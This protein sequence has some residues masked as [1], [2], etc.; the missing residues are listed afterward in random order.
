MIIPFVFSSFQFHDQCLLNEDVQVSSDQFEE[1]ESS[2]IDIEV[3]K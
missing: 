2:A 1:E 3:F